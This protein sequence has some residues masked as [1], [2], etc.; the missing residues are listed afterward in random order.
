M[1]FSFKKVGQYVSKTVWEREKKFTKLL[2]LTVGLQV[3]EL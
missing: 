2:L 1:F 3:T